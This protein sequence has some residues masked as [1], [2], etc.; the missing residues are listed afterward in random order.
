MNRPILGYTPRLIGCAEI[1]FHSQ[2]KESKRCTRFWESSGAAARRLVRGRLGSRLASSA[3][4]PAARRRGRESRREA[5]RARPR[6][7]RSLIDAEDTVRE[8]LNRTGDTV[9]DG[10]ARTR[11]SVRRWGS[12]HESTADSTGTRRST[13]ASSWSK[14]EGGT[15]TI[16]GTV[17]DEAAKAKVDLAGERYFRR[18]PRRRSAPRHFTRQR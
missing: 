8:G 11:D 5:R 3:R 7:Q 2:R 4:S 6:H 16:R 14:A 9:R 1:H 13:P 12:P 10:F 17:P 18:D 15:V